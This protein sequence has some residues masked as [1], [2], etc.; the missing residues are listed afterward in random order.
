MISKAEID[1]YNFL[2]QKSFGFSSSSLNL[3]L[4]ARVTEK[5]FFRFTLQNK[6]QQSGLMNNNNLQAERLGIVSRINEFH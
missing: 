2:F 3:F 1:H 6:I 4:R 5:P